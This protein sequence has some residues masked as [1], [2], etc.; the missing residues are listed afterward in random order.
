MAHT[1][2]NDISAAHKIWETKGDL[3]A[4]ILDMLYTYK[5]S[6]IKCINK[7]SFV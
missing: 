1:E 3:Q 2:N 6:K 4:L 5:A 7:T